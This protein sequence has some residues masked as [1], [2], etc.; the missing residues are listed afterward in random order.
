MIRRL[1]TFQGYT[2][3]VRLKEFRKVERDKLPEFIPFESEAAIRLL[4]E[5]K[6]HPETIKTYQDENPCVIVQDIEIALARG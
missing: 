2:I 5:L 4:S 6:A 3:D 1:P